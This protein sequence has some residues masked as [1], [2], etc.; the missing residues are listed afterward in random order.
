MLRRTSLR[1]AAAAAA[2]ATLAGCGALVRSASGRGAAA[3]DAAPSGP[4]TISPELQWARTAWRYV[5]NNTDY[6]SGL[7]AGADRMAV[8]TAWNAGDALAA[9]VAAHELG[10][11]DAREFDQRLSRLLGFIGTMELS[12]GQVPNKAYSAASGK[13]V[14]FDGRPADI[15]WSALDIGRLL[16]WL[17]IVRQRHPRFAE[18]AD[19]AVLRWSFCE[20]IDDCGVLTGTSRTGASLSRYAE[21]RLGYEQLAAAGYAAW[22]FDMRRTLAVPPTE[23]VNIHG[24]PIRYDARDARTSGSQTPV[25]TMPYAFAAMELGAASPLRALADSV[26]HVQEERWRREKQFTARS[27]HQVRDAPYVVLDAVFAAGY[28]WNTIGHDGREYD[29]LAIVNTRAAFAMAALWPTDY[30]RE[31]MRSVQYLYDPDRGWYEGRFEAGGAPQDNITLSTNAAVLEALLFKAKG[32]LFDPAKDKPGH[33]ETVTSD[34]FNRLGRCHPKERP[35]CTP[36]AS[37]AA[38]RTPHPHPARPSASAS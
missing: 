21:G 34:P 13:M 4:R 30:T 25:L 8:F 18:Y 3:A 6:D 7:V 20:V 12:G 22:G 32:V 35:A 27:D 23:A 5:E 24:T 36:P 16:L 37:P 1:L 19:K 31:L 9:V 29:K 2:A 10:V 33:F 28:A 38:A 15:G 17:R 26:Y 11:I 14:G